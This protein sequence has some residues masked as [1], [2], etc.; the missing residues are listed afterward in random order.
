M[1]KCIVE[2][3]QRSCRLLLSFKTYE[4]KKSTA[5]VFS[6]YLCIRDRT[7][8]LRVRFKVLEQIN[9]F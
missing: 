9:F 4:A 7:F 8:D 1:K 5:I 2:V 6:H 3:F